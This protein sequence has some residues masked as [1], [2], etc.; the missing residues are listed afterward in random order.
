MGAPLIVRSVEDPEG[1]A[2]LI[3]SRLEELISEAIELRGRAHV[4]LSGGSTPRPAYELLAKRLADPDNLEIWFGDERAVPPDDA[5]SNFKLV[6]E[7]LAGSGL[8]ADAIHRIEGERDPE[9]AAA[10]YAELLTERLA[11]EDGGMPAL[12]LA[13]QGLGPDGHTASLFPDHPALEADSVCVAVHEAPKP[14]PERITLTVPALRAARKI[15]FLVTGEDK[16]K[17]VAAMLESPSGPKLPASLLVRPDTELIAD[18]AALACA[19]S[20][21]P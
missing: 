12:D 16:A 5:D 1:A 9:E 4:A 18:E 7:A 10:S 2:R 17:A 3:A 11:S 20:D 8:P 21:D 14:P 15:I 6:S 19:T 13:L